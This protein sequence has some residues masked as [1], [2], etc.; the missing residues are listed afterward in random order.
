MHVVVLLTC[1]QRLL[2]RLYFRQLVYRAYII[3]ILLSV[4]LA[5]DK[6]ECMILKKRIAVESDIKGWSHKVITDVCL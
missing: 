4:S 6:K 3:Y 2:S 5:L 1:E